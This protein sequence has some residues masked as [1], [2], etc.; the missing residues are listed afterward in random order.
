VAQATRSL[1]MPEM[2]H[3]VEEQLLIAGYDVQP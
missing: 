2:E 3:L 1:E